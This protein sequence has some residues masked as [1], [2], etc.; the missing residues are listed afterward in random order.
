M[1][2][3]PDI[4]NLLKI[5]EETEGLQERLRKEQGNAYRLTKKIKQEIIQRYKAANVTQDYCD[6]PVINYGG[7]GTSDC[8]CCDK[9]LT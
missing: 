1:A 7:M 8:A 3:L 4:S 2:D 5:V 9:P 6:H